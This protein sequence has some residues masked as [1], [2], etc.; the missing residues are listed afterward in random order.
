MILGGGGIDEPGCCL[1]TVSV[2]VG[3]IM[4]SVFLFAGPR[5]TGCL[6]FGPI[7]SITCA[8]VLKVNS[9]KTAMANTFM[10][11]YFT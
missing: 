11:F 5:Q 2:Y 7:V 3:G 8:D 1:C 9:V 4:G 6:L 10:V